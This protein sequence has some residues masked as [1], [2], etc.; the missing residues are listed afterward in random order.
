MAFD[1]NTIFHRIA[2]TA[3][4]VA[5]IHHEYLMELDGYAKNTSFANYHPSYL[6]KYDAIVC[7]NDDKKFAP[8]TVLII[9]SDHPVI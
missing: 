5:Y 2:Y 4:Q 1:L 8:A 3:T 6:E 9:L 7:F